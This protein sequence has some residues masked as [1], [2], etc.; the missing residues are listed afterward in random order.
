MQTNLVD[1]AEYVWMCHRLS[2]IVQGY[3]FFR[4]LPQYAC[5]RHAIVCVLKNIFFSL[6]FSISSF[7]ECCTTLYILLCSYV[8]RA[9]HY[10]RR[11]LLTNIKKKH[12]TDTYDKQT[13]AL[14]SSLRSF[15]RSCASWVNKK[16]FRKRK[17]KNVCDL[18]AMTKTIRIIAL[19][20]CS[21]RKMYTTQN[22]LL[23]VHQ[24]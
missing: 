11:V 14:F 23:I 3:L 16:Q 13:G 20:L 17:K 4:S 9:A 24:K 10:T 7:G 15:V 18:W 12:Q 21:R 2:I 6:L 19:N 5:L 22:I 8:R 1:L